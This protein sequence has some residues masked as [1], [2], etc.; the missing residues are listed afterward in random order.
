MLPLTSGLDARSQNHWPRV[1]FDLGRLV[2]ACAPL[3]PAGFY[4]KTFLWPGWRFYEPFIRRMAGLGPAPTQPD[5]DRYERRN[6]SCDVLVVGAG[7]AGLAAALAAAEAGARVLLVE[8]DVETGGS[9]LSDRIADGDASL[10]GWCERATRRLRQLPNTILLMRTTCTGAYDH[11]VLTLDEHVSTGE[12]ISGPLRALRRWWRVRARQVILATGAIEQPLV[13]PRND[14]PGV[15]LAGAVRSYLNRY[16]VSCGDRIVIATNNDAAYRTAID[17]SDAGAD[18]AAVLD[19]RPMIDGTLPGQARERD[20]RILHDALIENVH[21][22]GAIRAVTVATAGGTRRRRIACNALA[23]SGGHAPTL[24]LYCQALGRPRFDSAQSCH[25]PDGRLGSVHVVGAASGSFDLASALPI[26]FDT[27]L[28]AA[29]HAGHSGAVDRELPELPSLASAPPGG[30]AQRSPLRSSRAWVDFQHDVTTRDIEMAVTENYVSV[31]HLKRYTTLGMSVDQGKTSNLNALAILAELTGRNIASVGTTTFRP[32]FT[33]VT[34]ST[35]AGGRTGS[36][37]R[38]VHEVPSHARQLE[39][40]AV[41][42]DFGGWRRPVVYPADGESNADATAREVRAV[43]NAVGLF[44]AS[45]LGKIL[46][47]GP[48]AGEFLNRVY[49]NDL[50]TLAVGR[51][52]YGLMLN[53]RGVIID[54]GVCMRLGADEYWVGTTSNGASRIAAWLDEWLQCEWPT[55]RAIVT[56]VTAQWATLTVAGPRARQVLG[57]LGT[58]IDL[59]N[60]AFPHLAVR[61]G[62]LG[63]AACRAAR[64][65]YTGELSYEISVAADRGQSLWDLLLEAGAYTGIEPFGIEALMTLRIE[66]GFLHVGS[67]TDG[68][69]IPD[70]VGFGAA[71]ARKNVDFIGR[72]SLLLPENRGSDRLQFVGLRPA[73]CGDRLVAGAHLV[74]EATMVGASSNVGPS[75]GYVTSACASP[76]LGRDVALGLLR[77]GR[78]RLGETVTV[79][80]AGTRHRAVVVPTGA[81]DPASVRLHG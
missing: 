20:I 54:D 32:P 49:A 65:S 78:V 69:T 12:A 56:D 62:R 40:G 77:N 63:G 31:E 64:V 57:R 28:A 76:T 61:D 50:S 34:L 41:L 7:P 36:F 45:P 26:A 39:L 72:R 44:E 79:F 80:D 53:E 22:F 3:F 9:A 19:T 68:S 37:Y 73:G 70:D 46:V 1:E 47:R 59:S 11:G 18:V 8:Q 16:A 21:G 33:P 43:R 74:D 67:D 52:R 42:E 55:L 81:Y 75:A 6:A 23:V 2:D 60:P 58:G 27:G 38:P 71:V 17:L 4:N 48:D 35:I 15:M 25:V 14:R 5:P 51:A 10:A 66:K 30:P 24:H 29:R 13:F